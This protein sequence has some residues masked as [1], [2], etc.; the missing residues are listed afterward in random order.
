[1]TVIVVSR[2]QGVS[3]WIILTVPILFTLSQRAARY[4]VF[5][6]FGPAEAGY[7]KTG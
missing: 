1:M 6:D 5:A 7:H 2:I 4:C 3:A